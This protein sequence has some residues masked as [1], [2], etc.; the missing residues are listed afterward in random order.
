M[1]VSICMASFNRDPKV[2]DAVLNSICSQTCHFPVE[3]V[4]ADDGSEFGAPDV[5][6][7][8][9]VEYRRI[10]REPAVRNP[11]VARN[12]AYRQASGDIIIAQSDD[13]VHEDGAVA[14]LV[15]LL[16]NNSSSFV[17]ATVLGC[18]RNGIPEEVYTGEW[19]GQLRHLPLFFLGALW[20]SDLYAI[21]GN[22]EEFAVCGGNGGQEDKW[23]A[24]CLI[25][26]RGLSPVYA[27][28]VVGYHMAHDRPS[29]RSAKHTNMK[30]YHQKLER[31]M[32]TG[33]WCS[34][35][36]P[37]REYDGATSVGAVSRQSLAFADAGRG[38]NHRSDP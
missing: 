36:G 7:N 20:K 22:D 8:Y 38:E 31:A 11:S 35:S 18:D 19:N 6:G 21:G 15:E 34:S 32:N 5:C 10:D 25:D 30:L 29:E 37:W 23:F 33:V 14:E 12:I 2:L 27:E 9:P 17:I 26:G 4:V 1:N 28:N 24:R 13:V 3:V 16:E